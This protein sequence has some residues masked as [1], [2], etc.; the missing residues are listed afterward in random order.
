MK[1]LLFWIFLL[2]ALVVIGLKTGVIQ[3]EHPIDA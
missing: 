1:K 3:I 2:G